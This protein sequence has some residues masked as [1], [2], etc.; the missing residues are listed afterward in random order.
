MS[1]F[2]HS[3]IH[4]QPKALQKLAF[5]DGPLSGF[6]HPEPWRDSVKNYLTLHASSCMIVPCDYCLK[7]ETNNAADA[8]STSDSDSP[9][10]TDQ[11]S[12]DGKVTTDPDELRCC[13]LCSCFE[14]CTCCVIPKHC[15]RLYYTIQR[16]TE[17]CPSGCPTIVPRPAEEEWKMPG[18]NAREFACSPCCHSPGGIMCLKYWDCLC[19]PICPMW[20]LCK[21]LDHGYRRYRVQLVLHRYRDSRKKKYISLI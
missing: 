3:V 7:L 10:T 20:D 17:H 8:N 14:P 16:S 2:S 15:D 13:L 5:G 11:S 6:P 9:S 19:C 12:E 1:T 21:G 18:G 4:K